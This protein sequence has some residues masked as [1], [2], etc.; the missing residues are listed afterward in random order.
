MND[1]FEYI[2]LRDELAQSDTFGSSYEELLSGNE[3]TA[4]TNPFVEDVGEL[5]NG[6]LLKYESLTEFQKEMLDKI[7]DEFN[8]IRQSIDPKRLKSFEHYMNNDDELLLFR[9]TE[10][11]LINIII[12]P[13]DCI[14][15]SFIPNDEGQRQFYIV[16]PNG[17]FEKLAYDFFSR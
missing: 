8:N 13:E 3:S 17:D 4:F 9:E 1:T 2:K 11:G 14:S 12:N 15:F 10:R 7:F 16:H 6:L 5:L